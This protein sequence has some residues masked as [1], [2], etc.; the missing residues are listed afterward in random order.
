MVP[1]FPP[2]TICEQ[3]QFYTLPENAYIQITATNSSQFFL[4]HVFTSALPQIEAP[5]LPQ[6]QHFNKL[7]STLFG[8]I[9]THFTIFLV[10]WFRRRRFFFFI[11]FIN[12]Y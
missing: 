3:T 1:N 2:G 5:T 10:I 4:I 9:S 11:N 6:G 8:D 12:S 7:D